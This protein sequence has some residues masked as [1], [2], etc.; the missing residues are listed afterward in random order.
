MVIN[1]CTTAIELYKFVKDN[2][3]DYNIFDHEGQKDVLL[4][5][6][7]IDI[8]DF[9]DLLGNSIFDEDGISCTMKKNYFCFWMKDICDYYGIELSEIFSI[10]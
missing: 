6:N 4:F 2:R 9:M 8:K 1:N 10:L 7:V 3:L 5:V